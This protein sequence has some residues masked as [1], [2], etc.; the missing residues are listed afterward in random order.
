MADLRMLPGR[1]RWLERLDR[2]G[3]LLTRGG[4]GQCPM[5][6]MRAGWSEWVYRHEKTHEEM[7]ATEIGVWEPGIWANPEFQHWHIVS[8]RITPA[9]RA[10]LRGEG[11][12]NG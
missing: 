4:H 6:C 3:P 12:E 9:G 11:V 2:E 10:A 7:S 5:A 8:E 1:R